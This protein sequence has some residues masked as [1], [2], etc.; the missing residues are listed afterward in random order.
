MQRLKYKG[1]NIVSNSR[2]GYKITPISNTNKPQG[3]YFLSNDIIRFRLRKRSNASSIVFVG[4]ANPHFF[5]ALSECLVNKIPVKKIIAVDNNSRQ[6]VHFDMLRKYI[7]NSNNRIEYIQ[8][9]FKIKFN[10]RAIA[11]LEK[12]ALKSKQVTGGIEKDNFFPMEKELWANSIF[13]DTLFYNTYGIRAKKENIGLKI[14]SNTIGDINT[15]YATILTGSKNDYPY[16]P[17]TAAYGTGFLKDDDSFDKLKSVLATVPMYQINEDISLIYEELLLSN[18]YKPIIFWSSNVFCDYFVDKNVNIKNI[19]SKSKRYGTQLDP[20]LPE[21]DLF[22]IQDERTKIN[23]PKNIDNVRHHKRRWGVHTKNFNRVL[24]YIRGTRNLEI[25]NV[26]RWIQED[27]GIS[28]L[29]N[30]DYMTLDD[31]ILMPNRGCF[32]SIF[33]HII[34][35]NGTPLNR[36]EIVLRKIV[37]LTKNI[38]ILE[39]NKDSIDFKNSANS[40]S[41]NYFRDLLG[42]ESFIEFCPGEKCKNRNILLIYRNLNEHSFSHA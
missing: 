38:I 34:V 28:K 8:N 20:I 5:H 1:I 21:I 11:L 16:W 29:P 25:V 13:F 6:L 12:L 18:R 35:G 2:E 30:T 15:Y 7:L 33:L 19:I 40:I 41:L 10:S 31:F 42:K 3:F 32:D 36:F 22:I 27:S 26:E 17:F 37:T 14:K 39:H 9:L 23:L 4:I 24:K